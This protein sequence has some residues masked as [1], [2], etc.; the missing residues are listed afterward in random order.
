M[1]LDYFWNLISQ[2][3]RASNG[4]LSTQVVSLIEK[5]KL[6]TEDNILAYRTIFED[7]MNRSNTAALWEAADILGCGCSEDD[8]LDFRGWLIAQ[9]KEIYENAII[10]PESLVNVVNINERARHEE[11]LYVPMYAYEQKTGE[12]LP[13]QKGSIQTELQGTHWPE[14]NKRFPKLAAKF[15][16]CSRLDGYW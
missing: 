2:S 6:E 8:F 15:G 1:D 14:K 12:P 3:Q 10:D 13:V 7:L 11:F 16:D 9:G 5:L 4:D